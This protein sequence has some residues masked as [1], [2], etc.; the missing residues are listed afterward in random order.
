MMNVGKVQSSENSIQRDFQVK[1]H[2]DLE[3]L[4]RRSADL[5]VLEIEGQSVLNTVLSVLAISGVRIVKEAGGP[6]GTFSEM[7]RSFEEWRRKNRCGKG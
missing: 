2:D 3:R 6:D 7:V 4:I 1:L 5:M